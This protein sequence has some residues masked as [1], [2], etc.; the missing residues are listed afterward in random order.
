VK[1]EA[2]TRQQRAAILLA[3]GLLV[4]AVYFWMGA[5]HPGEALLGRAAFPV[6]AGSHGHHGGHGPA[7]G[8]TLPA[9]FAMWLAMMVAMMLP[10]VL[11]WIWFF[12]AATRPTAPGWR[13]WGR[14]LLFASGYF[15]LWALYS[16]GAAAAQTQLAA[17]ALL[18]PT[19]LKVAPGAGGALLLLA[20]AVQFTPLK[21]ACLKHCR[22]PLGYFLTR[23]RNGPMGAFSMG[24]RHGVYCLGCCW[25]LMALAFALGTMN[26]LWMAA[27]T[28]LLCVEKI[29]PGGERWSKAF[30]AAFLLWGAAVLLGQGG[31]SAV[32]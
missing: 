9:A 1:A 20:G 16:A 17:H 3:S 6:A 15:A 30:G 18:H 25:A 7:S 23:W 8:V 32:F 28:L 2:L 10:P 5:A 27:V 24:F 31:G 19:A 29:A 12:A 21:N 4:A 14:T 13:L 11:P 22:S 26:L